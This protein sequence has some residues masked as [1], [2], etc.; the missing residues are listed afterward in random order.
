VETERVAVSVGAGVVLGGVGTLASPWQEGRRTQEQDA[1]DHKGP[2][3]AQPYPRPYG[4]EGA[5]ETMSY[6]I[7]P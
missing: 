1:G 7:Y 6:N 3:P 5:S 4:Y 2:R